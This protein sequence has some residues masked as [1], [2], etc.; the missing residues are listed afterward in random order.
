MFRFDCC[1]RP[2]SV[3]AMAVVIR[4][5]DSR[6]HRSSQDAFRE[7]DGLP[8]QARQQRL[9]ITRQLQFNFFPP[10]VTPSKNA[11]VSRLRNSTSA[12]MAPPAEA[13][14]VTVPGL[15]VIILTPLMFLPACCGSNSGLSRSLVPVRIS[16]FALI[17]ESALAVS[18]LKPGVVPTSCRS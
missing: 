16:V 13:W 2:E 6:I 1:D 7:E 9:S 14:P 4:G 18:P 17:E 15:I 11:P 3:L 8:G 5:L 12:G 10:S